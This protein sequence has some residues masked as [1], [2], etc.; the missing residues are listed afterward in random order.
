MAGIVVRSAEGV[1]F[2]FVQESFARSRIETVGKLQS[3]DK[4][5]EAAR[6]FE[7][8]LLGHWLEQAQ[9]SLASAP[10]GTDEDQEDPAH[11]QLQGIGM[12]SLATAIT[13][14]G[15]IGIAA[16]IKH[17]LYRVGGANPISLAP[18]NQKD[19]IIQNGKSLEGQ[20]VQEKTAEG[21]NGILRTADKQIA[22]GNEP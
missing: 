19:V 2:G 11:F 4:I 22:E 21:A 18:A 7:S 9:E 3:P 5:E 20:L 17:Q 10:G 16:L 13:Q 15:G 1:D 8:V 14:A 6:D 12:Q